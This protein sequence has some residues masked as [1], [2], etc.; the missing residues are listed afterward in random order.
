MALL[1]N[2]KAGVYGFHCP[3]CKHSHYYTTNENKEAQLHWGFNGNMAKP[4]FT[5]SLLNR[6]GKHVDP[7]WEEPE[8]EGPEGGWSGI[9]HLFV[10]DGQIIYCSDSTHKLAG[11][12]VPMVDYDTLKKQ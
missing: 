8:G 11:Q 12:T 9:C 1:H 5:P 2:Q 4:T 10:T 6:W 7:N 3:G